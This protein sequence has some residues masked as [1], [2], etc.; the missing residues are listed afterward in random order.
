MLFE[1]LNRTCLRLVP[2]ALLICSLFCISQ[3]GAAPLLKLEFLSSDKITH[4]SKGLNEPS[5]LA[6]SAV[7]GELWVVSDDT[8]AVFK[9]NPNDPAT[10]VALPIRE[11]E[12]E[13]ITLAENEGYFFT[14]NEAKGRISQFKIADGQR[15]SRQKIRSMKGYEGIR[16]SIKV[17]GGKNGFEGMAWHSERR[18]LFVVLEGPP[19]L[20]VE[21]SSD[22][23]NILSSQPLTAAQGFVTP[24][25]AEGKIDFSGLA[26]DATRDRLWILS[27][28]AASVFIFDLASSR[29]VQSLRLRRLNSKGKRK[30]V[31]QPEGIALSP[32]GTKLYVV[33]D[34]KSQ[35]YQW[36][37]H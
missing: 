1:R 36:R 29:V 3:L 27:D 15:R 37:V 24:N 8:G 31:G 17:A 12:M 25:I 22:L 13:A 2:A 28:Q 4:T 16:R 7:T 23:K 21:M 6:V 9:L 30:K 10:V 5:G 34:S 32:D 11:H 18:S 19:G 14:L 33:S 20:L 35:L 26:Y